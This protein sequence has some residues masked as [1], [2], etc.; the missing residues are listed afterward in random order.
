[1]A[2]ENG[3]TFDF[4]MPVNRRNTSSLK[5]DRYRGTDTLPLW[6]AD[7]DFQA[8]PAVLATLR[9]R[10]D[11]GVFGYTLPSD[12]LMDAVLAMLRSAHAW[13]VRPEWVVWLPGLV[14]GLNVACRCVGEPGDE[15][16][17]TTPA[18]PPFLSAP[19][20]AQRSL[21]NVPHVAEA[22]GYAFDFD[23]MERS[24]TDRTRMFILC[25]PHNP[26]GRVFTRAELERLAG[27]CLSGGMV[28]CSDEI[29]C[30]L[31]LDH[32]KAHL[33]IAALDGEVARRSITLLA[34][35]KTYNLPGLGCSLAVIPDND[36]RSRFRQVMAGI[37]PHV[38]ALG[39]AAALAAYRDCE[40]WRLELIGY[41]REN[42]DLVESF[43]ANSGGLS[44]HHVE[45]TYLAW[46][47]CR[48]IGHDDPAAFFEQAGVGLSS[49][50]DFGTPGF[51][52]LNF[53]CRRSL[54]DEA[55]S[56]MGS[57]LGQRAEA[58]AP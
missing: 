52:R 13:E 42:R 19:S 47:D 5:W 4:D 2:R 1:M 22:S 51:V 46:I 39:F 44:M 14:T 11:H 16:M 54:L 12:D 18:Y 27:L 28:I 58:P 36:L 7:M 15:I 45:A 25:N 38:N 24:A 3:I 50:A 17:T 56:R 6:V 23:R 34:P 43:V 10:V 37:V 32:D 9:K 20:M 40:D 8:P 41:L 26:T 33:S 49:G 35:S 31:V 57:A 21:I 30:G 29:H 55:L 48:G 53:G